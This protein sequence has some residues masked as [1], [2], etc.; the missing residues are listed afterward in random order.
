M[1]PDRPDPRAYWRANLRLVLTLLAIWATV[2]FGGSILFIEQ[3]NAFTIG[4]V[5][6]GFWLA[7]QGSIYVF[8]V[9]I[10]VYAWRMDALD[11]KHGVDEER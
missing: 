3:L 6:L 11:R 4:S 2:S 8:V 10:F 5:P 7:Q 1:T 9:L